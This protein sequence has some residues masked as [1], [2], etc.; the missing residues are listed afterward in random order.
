MSA[1]QPT[2]FVAG[3]AGG[4]ALTPTGVVAGQDARAGSLARAMCALAVSAHPALARA[5]MTTRHQD[6]A[7]MGALLQKL[8]IT[9]G[10]IFVLKIV[11]AYLL[12]GKYALLAF[13][14]GLSVAFYALAMRLCTAYTDT[15]FSS[16]SVFQNIV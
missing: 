13:E 10:S 11:R 14:L 1:V 12:D 9:P 15:Y 4:A 16:A 8:I 2:L 3:R 7:L 5:P 6:V